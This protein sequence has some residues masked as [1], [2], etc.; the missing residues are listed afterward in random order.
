MKQNRWVVLG[1]LL[2]VNISMGTGYAWSVFTGP[3]ADRFGWDSVQL[4]LAYTINMGIAPIPMLLGARLQRLFGDKKNILIGGMI[5]GI[6][7]VITGYVNSLAGFYV[8]YG[9]LNG[10]GFNIAFSAVMAASVKHFPDKSGMALGAVMAGFPF[11]SLVIAPIATLLMNEYGVMNAFKIL[12]VTVFAIV[13]LCSFLIRDAQTIQS[14][15]AEAKG[16][17]KSGSV[18]MPWR[19]MFLDPGYYLILLLFG[20]GVFGGVMIISSAASIAKGMYLLPP[21][22]ASLIVGLIAVANGSGRVLGGSLFDKLGENRVLIVLYT[23]NLLSLL[24]LVFIKTQIAFAIAA[25]LIGFCYGA[26]IA[27]IASTINKRYGSKYF[28]ANYA[29]TFIAYSCLTYIAPRVAAG[30]QSANHGD[31]TKAFYIAAAVSIVGLVA[32]TIRNIYASRKIAVGRVEGR[33]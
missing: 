33:D 5:A 31:F 7:L 27:T 29:I 13:C 32:V 30:I 24:L 28:T 26:C 6:G 11:G 18:D 12:G 25:I 20:A 2:L 19:K 4:A 14:G 3:L 16:N 9:I 21:V 10:F 22:A 15:K 8:A 23:V 17:R 1:A